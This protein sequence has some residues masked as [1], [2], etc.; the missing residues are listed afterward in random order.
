MVHTPPTVTTSPI[1]TYGRAIEPLPPSHDSS[2]ENVTPK[3]NPIPHNIPPNTS[4]KILADPDSDPSL[5]DDSTSD[6]SNSSDD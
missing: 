5:S 2:A 6:S 1:F 3:G 4:P